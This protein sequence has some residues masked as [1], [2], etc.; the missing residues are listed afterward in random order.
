MEKHC[1]SFREK[2][3]FE[4]TDPSAHHDLLIGPIVLSLMTRQYRKE[5]QVD[6]MASAREKLL[7]CFQIHDSK[8][9]VSAYLLILKTAFTFLNSL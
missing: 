9:K 8:L 1:S 4:R 5:T 6:T 3:A 7:S 2:Y